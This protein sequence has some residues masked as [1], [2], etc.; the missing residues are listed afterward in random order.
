MI[1]SHTTQEQLDPMEPA[2]D[3]SLRKVVSHQKVGN[4]LLETLERGHTHQS[5][6]QQPL[7]EFICLTCVHGKFKALP[8]DKADGFA[9][10]RVWWLVSFALDAGNT[11]PAK[12]PPPGPY[13]ETGRN[14]RN[15]VVRAYIRMIEQLREYWPDASYVALRE[16]GTI[17][18]S[19][20]YPKPDWFEEG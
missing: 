12:W 20:K 15:T 13:W 17:T 9:R 14:E 19:E 3:F 4:I 7:D 10:A 16:A 5:A 2:G 8:H 18:Y 1:E 6:R 11:L